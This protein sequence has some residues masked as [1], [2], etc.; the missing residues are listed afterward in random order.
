M[1][2]QNLPDKKVLEL[3]A[4]YGAAALEARRKFLGLL[5]EVNRRGLWRRKGYGSI[6]EFAAKMAGVSEDQVRNVLNLER[7][8]AVL[9][10][11]RKALVSGRVSVNKLIRVAAVVTPENEDFWA[12]KVEILS[13]NAVATLVR[14][15]K[16]A[17]MELRAQPV[18]QEKHKFV[19]L[20]EGVADKLEKLAA[21]GLDIGQLLEEFLDKRE[22]E[23][24]QAETK[25]QEKMEL[26]IR[27][28][29]R[30]L[31]V[32]VKRL[33]LRRHGD[34]CAVEGCRKP[35]EQV[36]HLRPW[37][38]GGGQEPDNLKP[39]CRG[40]HELA[41]AGSGAGLLG[42]GYRVAPRGEWESQ[43]C[44]MAAR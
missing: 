8:F 22:A 44:S 31:P 10:Q 9:P 15:M 23:L 19:K 5:P 38:R 34:K 25:L 27:D 33:L 20:P 16:Q 4:Q 32:E 17:G 42:R 12:K 39:L 14:D 43:V 24:A 18:S 21:K 37:A 36:H 3:C 35:A 41:H 11:L 1:E 40:H 2:L 6:F 7:K 26:E 30:H 13:Q 29:S 28:R